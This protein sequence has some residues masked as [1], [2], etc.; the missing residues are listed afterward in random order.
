LR[1]KIEKTFIDY[2]LLDDQKY[3]QEATKAQRF[4][5][6]NSL[7]QVLLILKVQNTDPT[8]ASK[9]AK[10]LESKGSL[11]KTDINIFNRYFDTVLT[12]KKP[13]AD[14]ARL[15][16]EQNES[17]VVNSR[18]A[19]GAS[20]K[21]EKC[22]PEEDEDEMAMGCGGLFGDD[23]FGGG[24]GGYS[25][26]AAPPKNE[27]CWDDD[28]DLLCDEAPA[29]QQA[30]K[31][32]QQIQ[33]G[34]QELDKTKEY[35][36][37]HYY[38]NLNK[39]LP[40]PLNAFW[41]DFTKH[42]TENPNNK[43]FLSQN[44]IYSHSNLT[45]LIA[46]L[47]LISLPFKPENHTQSPFE[48]RGIE[49]QAASDFITFTKAVTEAQPELKTDILI[50]QRF[51]DPQE[52]YTESEDEPGVQ[53]EK[54]VDQYI[55]N[56]VYGS[57]VIITNSSSSLQQLQVLVEIPEGA[58]PVNA[59]DYTKSHN[60][61]L[62]SFTTQTIEFYFYFPQTGK[63]KVNPPNVSKRGKVIAIGQRS[64]IEVKAQKTYTSLETLSAVLT[65]GSQEDVLNFARTKNIWNPK[66]F[67][68][69]AIY[70][71]LK[72]ES[73]FLK[74]IEILRDRRYFDPLVWRFGFLHNDIPTIQEYLASDPLNPISK[75][76]QYISSSL[77]K[78]D[79]L[80]LLEYHPYI[81]QRVHLLAD[82]K[83]R[84]LN[85]QLKEQYKNYIV[86]LCERDQLYTEHY[87]GLIY[88]L[89]LQDRVE[90]AIKFFGKIDHEQIQKD[91]EKEL[92]YDY[93]AAY[94][95]FYMGY[96]KFSVAT[97]ICKKYLQYPVLSW[98]SLFLDVS[99][100]LA[101]F[102][103]QDVL[104][105]ETTKNTEKRQNKENA[106]KEE[107]AQ[108][109]LKDAE[110]HITHQNVKEITLSFYRIDLEVLFSRNPFITQGKDEF[111]YIQ[112]SEVQKIQI[113]NPQDLQK[114]TVS[115]PQNLQKYNLHVEM[116]AE[117]KRSSATYFSTSLNV[118]ILENYGQVKVLDSND[119]PL[120]KTYVKC[121]AQNKNGKVSFY[122]DGYTDL[123]GRFDYATLNS[124]DIS[125]IEKFALFIMNDDLGS[126]IKEAKAP[127]KLSRVGI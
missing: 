100:Q 93:F 23:D 86:Y 62:G 12:S 6:L 77:L 91:Q 101:E 105:D 115:I 7:E 21:L 2:F 13:E 5:E 127:S 76:F 4:R 68:F 8:L 72:E 81:N 41:I 99:N 50:T 98:R 60:I 119:R 116:R 90:E 94:L 84:I 112:P 34:F 51:F 18:F 40:I 125:N 87:L 75:N 15:L 102:D 20:R 32:R 55:F 118:H 42:I 27:A 44:F 78:V 19:Y 10:S 43:P 96:P 109:E 82:S 14:R 3:L 92:Q 120:I 26:A 1:N 59:L 47:S 35:T 31:Q 45:E 122:K 106:Q 48:G 110:L 107:V 114:K 53:V 123:R 49:I 113:D 73:F 30:L 103:G 38:N 36:E 57:T 24:G 124:N 61:Q 108:F 117:D 126:V 95:D 29:L 66:V 80:K 37:R 70:W 83:N 52:K 67:D 65:K 104:E 111:S 11:N 46:T 74:F 97:D 56:K 69:N 89:L 88:Y 22:A 63:F 33:A 85:V 17:L 39:S 121:F 9:L 58:I 79:Q 28:L 54:E 16:R 71:L 25:Y 64:E